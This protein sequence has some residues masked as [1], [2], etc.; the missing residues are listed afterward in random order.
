[1]HGC[2]YSNTTCVIKLICPP[3]G[4][5]YHDASSLCFVSQ[6]CFVFLISILHCGPMS[7]V[8]Q[9]LTVG[10]SGLPLLQP[11]HV[12]SALP[13]LD[14]I[15]WLAGLL[16]GCLLMPTCKPF[17]SLPEAES[18]VS[19]ERVPWMPYAPSSVK[20]SYGTIWDRPAHIVALPHCRPCPVTCEA[21]WD[22]VWSCRRK[23]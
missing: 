10:G 22:T 3:H 20:N 21:V 1:M 15:A 6:H 23:S 7:A 11:P 17:G 18:Q 16:G 12:P 5:Y 14:P 2:C 13:E 4:Y 9:R 8:Q 19:H